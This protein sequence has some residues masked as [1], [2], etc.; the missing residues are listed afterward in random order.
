PGERALNPSGWHFTDDQGHSQ[1][2]GIPPGTWFLRAVGGGERTSEWTGPIEVRAKSVTPLLLQL[3][4]CATL[5]VRV[6]GAGSRG[7]NLVAFDSRRFEVARGY[8]QKD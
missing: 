4:D 1:I 3:V 6:S 2:D 8:V 7:A 5:I